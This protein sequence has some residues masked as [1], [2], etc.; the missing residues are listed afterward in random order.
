MNKLTYLFLGWWNS[1][2]HWSMAIYAGTGRPK[3]YV[4]LANMDTEIK[5]LIKTLV[6]GLV[7]AGVVAQLLFAVLMIWNSQGT[8][9]PPSMKVE[10]SESLYLELLQQKPPQEP[11]RIPTLDFNAGLRTAENGTGGGPSHLD[12]VAARKGQGTPLLTSKHSFEGE[13]PKEG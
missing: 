12:V 4:N 11:P 7:G 3:A 6:P 10:E 9:S 5:T 8:L 1:C 13:I 2:Y